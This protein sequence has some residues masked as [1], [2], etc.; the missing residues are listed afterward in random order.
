MEFRQ[1]EAFVAVAEKKSFSLAADALYLSQST[2]SSH[3]KNLEKELKK[4]LIVRTTKSLRLTPE[5]ETFLHYAKRIVET[6][7]AALAAV[8]EHSQSVLR[9]GASSIPSAFL[10]PEIIRR[11]RDGY[12]DVVC[13]V[14]QGDSRDIHEMLQDGTV[15]IGLLGQEFSSAKCS[16]IPLCADRLVL[17]APATDEYRR[18]KEEGRELPEILKSPYIQRERGSGTEAVSGQILREL[19]MSPTSLHIVTGTNDLQSLTRM[20]EMGVGVSICSELAVREA[21]E[22]G[23]ILIWPLHTTATRSFY[24]AHC[25]GRS[26]S[27]LMQEFLDC[28]LEM[29]RG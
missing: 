13:E 27:P 8:S 29:Y 26:L 28:A 10:L 4:Q 21:A 14:R 22:Q 11:F 7:D 5:G 20:I 23:R 16:Y 3:V 17:A 6:R 25:G 12:P 19:G 1:L 15:D 9:L 24:I 2:V 18:M